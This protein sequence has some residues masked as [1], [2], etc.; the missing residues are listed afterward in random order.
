MQDTIDLPDVWWR[1]RFTP[2]RDVVR[3]RLTGRL[4]W[5][6][7]LRAAGLP[8]EVTAWIERVI[9]KAR[10]PELLGTPA[11]RELAR[12]AAELVTDGLPAE[13]VVRR[14]GDVA[15][16]AAGLRIRMQ[17]DRASLWRARLAAS[18]LPTE[19]AAV[20]DKVTRKTGLWTGEKSAVAAELTGHFADG[21]AAGRSPAELIGS[22]GR[23]DAAAKLIRRAKK[24]NRPWIW[25]AAVWIAWM[26][27]GV[28]GVYG[29]C[30][31]WF[32]T[33]HPSPPPAVAVA[34]TNLV[35]VADAAWPIWHRVLLGAYGFGKNGYQT[36]LPI[37]TRLAPEQWRAAVRLWSLSKQVD[38]KLAGEAASLP[39]LGF[40][41]SS[42]DP[43]VKDSPNG[44]ICLAAALKEDVAYAVVD[45]EKHR[46][47]RDLETLIGMA[48][49]FRGDPSPRFGGSTRF[50]LVWDLVDA[51]TIAVCHAPQWLDD[52]L[53]VELA[54]A[55][56]G[57]RFTIDYHDPESDFERFTRELA[58][59]YTDDGNGDGRITRAGLRALAAESRAHGD[60]EG[61]LEKFEAASVI[62][63]AVA[64]RA[65]LFAEARHL[66]DIIRKIYSRPIGD[67]DWSEYDAATAVLNKS[68]AS[69]VYWFGMPR[70]VMD[71]HRRLVPDIEATLGARDGLNVG[72]ALELYRRHHDG[73][74]PATLAELVPGILAEVP[75][76]RVA[77]GPVR[78]H[79][80]D[81]KPVIY[82]I[83][84]DGVDDGGRSRANNGRFYD[85]SFLLG[86]R[87]GGDW[88]LFP[89]G[90]KAFDMFGVKGPGVKAAA[91]P[92]TTAPAGSAK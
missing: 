59:R 50:N 83:C 35:P 82:S 73:K 27:V 51:G 64:S 6:R 79:I 25:H 34:P 16:A 46:C 81:G 80:I 75:G 31:L 1:L 91:K 45:G 14:L 26:P 84:R 48:R 76:D 33:G 47:R 58:E 61:R 38:F 70:S 52:K 11:V 8:G 63:G 36:S 4:D 20:V 60:D 85:D 65:E 13:D 92:A 55:V 77:G 69:K 30:A 15:A 24:R 3:G 57:P 66:T 17:P 12:G 53:L 49:Q 22:F 44:L 39:A 40:P 87:W 88:I 29:L 41:A 23:V 78:Y 90:E 72:I 62:P 7:E 43:E 56:V 19:V 9:R 5:R 37:D 74:Y 54:H 2:M 71:P 18:G 21:L 42:N 32:L 10:L 86:H 67:N 89:P 68:E 28:F